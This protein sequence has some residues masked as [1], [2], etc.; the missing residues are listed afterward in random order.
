MHGDIVASF[1]HLIV[2]SVA[3]PD[4]SSNVVR[5]VW[6]VE[7]S[8]RFAMRNEPFDTLSNSVAK[9]NPQ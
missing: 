4:Q 8:P 6:E 9:L 7:S 3:S 2:K 1:N 5:D